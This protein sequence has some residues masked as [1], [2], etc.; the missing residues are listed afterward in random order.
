MPSR[1]NGTA[2]H[3][4]GVV[5]R[6]YR[7]RAEL[8]RADL[9]ARIF[10]SE[11]LI[12]AIERGERVATE[13]VTRDLEGVRELQTNGVLLDLRSRFGDTLSYQ[14]YPPWFQDWAIYEAEAT[15]LRWFEPNV[16]PGLL[17]TE[18]YARAI[19]RSRFGVSAEEIEEQV[20]GRMKRQEILARDDPPRL[21]VLLDEFVLRRP[22][23]GR[24]VMLDQVEKLIE[25]ANQPSTMLQV[26]PASVGAHL[27]LLGHFVVADFVGGPSVGYQDAAVR[28]MPVE[29]VE[30]V[31]ALILTWDTLRGEALPR[32][33]S[34]ALMEEAV[35][36]WT[37]AA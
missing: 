13:E 12:E 29:D 27:G 21:W 4:F 1:N 2:R 18:D 9:A 8:S 10:K 36:S 14:V 26:I 20:A 32:A 17:Q 28:G 23:G 33:A 19:F 15:Q 16:V 7:E 6:T 34:R 37:S 3:A 30:D 5:L 24:H 22:V 25:A 35:K 31:A 11:S